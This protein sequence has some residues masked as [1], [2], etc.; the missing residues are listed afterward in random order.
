VSRVHESIQSPANAVDETATNEDLIERWV[1]RAILE[2]Q[3]GNRDFAEELMVDVLYL[4]GRN[5][6]SS[7]P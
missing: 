2:L 1:R 6:S 4:I 5:G 3:S 7:T